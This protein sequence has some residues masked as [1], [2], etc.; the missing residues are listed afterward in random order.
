MCYQD[1][2][3]I[4]EICGGRVAQGGINWTWAY[5]PTVLAGHIFHTAITS[6]CEVETR[7][8]YEKADATSGVRFR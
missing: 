2:R 1:I 7:G 6:D 4:A 8:V 3:A 5:F